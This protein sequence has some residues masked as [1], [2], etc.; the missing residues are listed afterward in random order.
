MPLSRR[1]LWL[2]QSISESEGPVN[3]MWLIYELG[4]QR[5]P[6]SEHNNCNRCSLE[7]DSLR[8]KNINIFWLL[9]FFFN[10]N[11]FEFF[12][13]CWNFQGVWK[14]KA[15]NTLWHNVKLVFWNKVHA[16]PGNFIKACLL[17]DVIFP[18]R[19]TLVN[20]QLSNITMQQ[21][22]EFNHAANSNDSKC[23][24]LSWR[25]SAPVRGDVSSQTARLRT[26][27]PLAP[28]CIREKERKT[29][30]TPANLNLHKLHTSAIPK[31]PK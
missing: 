27:F 1:H 20:A 6:K 14:K 16:K 4:S 11:S 31:H 2:Y 13:I 28:D 8:E 26:S 18:P 7:R 19:K 3:L 30:K 22:M 9:L 24:W 29:E 5:N 25:L 23:T 17:L 21:H 12:S 10:L 15:N